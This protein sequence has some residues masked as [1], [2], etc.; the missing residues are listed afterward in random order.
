MLKRLLFTLLL[1][2]PVAMAQG[3]RYDNFVLRPTGTAVS[4]ATIEVCT[5]IT[6]PLTACTNHTA[7]LYADQALTVA[8][9]NPITS[10][11]NGNYG[12][13]AAPG[14]YTAT[15]SASGFSTETVAISLPCADGT[16]CT[17]SEI[18][19]II[20]VDGTTYPCTS[21]GVTSAISAAI[22]KVVLSPTCNPLVFSSTVTIN[23]GIVI[24]DETNISGPSTG[25]VFEGTVNGIHITGLSRSLGAGVGTQSVITVNAN[26]D[27][28]YFDP[29]VTDWRVSDLRFNDGYGS[30]RTAGAAVYAA[31]N[32]APAQNSDGIVTDI[33]CYQL[34]NCVNMQRPINT[35]LRNVSSENLLGEGI[36]LNGDGT[37][38]TVINPTCFSDGGT[39]IHATWMDGVQVIGGEASD[40]G[41]IGMLVDSN[42]TNVSSNIVVSG[43]DFEANSVGFESQDAEYVTILG[44]FLNNTSDGIRLEG[45]TSFLINALVR[46]SGGYGLNLGVTSPLSNVS[47]AVTV[48]GM[49]NWSGN[50]SGNL[51]NPN[52]AIYDTGE[53]RGTCSM[54]AGTTCTSTV[55]YGT[56][57]VVSVN[58]PG[59]SIAA[60]CSISGTTLTVTAASSNSDTWAWNIVN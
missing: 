33:L 24:D 3:V 51:N 1:I 13:W 36:V 26:T 42:G 28:I 35:T 10:D 56:H 41:Q 19:S 52:N 58:T 4:G 5:G 55:I 23:K 29:G 15:I 9:S 43:T 16:S 54:A 39:C 31:A 12:F 59:A 45:G 6:Y 47:G 60:G 57:C 48:T 2:A 25:Y 49:Q 7:S 50:T 34:E 8:D 38:V 27:A 53:S 30:G 14:G 21:A 17:L 11:T 44:N 32:P 18:N 37:T 40:S 20:Y 46:N 22:S